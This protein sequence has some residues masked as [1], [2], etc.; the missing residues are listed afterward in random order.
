[1]VCH[2]ACGSVNFAGN[3]EGNFAGNSTQLDRDGQAARRALSVSAAGKGAFGENPVVIRSLLVDSLALWRVQGT[4][5]ETADGYA[6]SV[7]ARR[8][9]HIAAGRA[10][11]WV[12]VAEGCPPR[13]CA[14]I[15]GVLSAIREALEV[16]AGAA[17]RIAPGRADA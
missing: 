7:G 15:V 10:S 1:M 4:V 5:Q 12:V 3:F 11:R 17:L 8:V 14:S 2:P 13:E 16:S 6:I 9:V